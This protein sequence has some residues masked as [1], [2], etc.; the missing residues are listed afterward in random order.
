MKTALLDK[1]TS[2]RTL[3]KQRA[4]TPAI[5]AMHLI[6]AD[7]YERAAAGESLSDDIRALHAAIDAAEQVEFAASVHR[8][9]A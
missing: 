3:L 6:L 7:L 4:S 9:G 1:A 8:I 2:H 5:A